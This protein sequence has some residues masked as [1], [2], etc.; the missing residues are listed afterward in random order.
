[1]PKPIMLDLTHPSETRTALGGG[2]SRRRRRRRGLRWRGIGGAGRLGAAGSD[3]GHGDE[4]DVGLA[5]E[6]VGQGGGRFRSN[7]GIRHPHDL[8]SRAHIN[9]HAATGIKPSTGHL[10]TMPG[11]LGSD[12]RFHLVSEDLPTGGDEGLLGAIWVLAV[13]DGYGWAGRAD[14]DAGSAVAAAVAAL[15]PR[16][17][18]HV[19]RSS[20]TF[21]I[22]SRDAAHDSAS[23][24]S[25]SNERATWP[26]AEELSVISPSAAVSR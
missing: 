1:M 12:D 16:D 4:R 24:R 11:A 8:G 19:H 20:A 14:L 10:A 23:A 18:G 25:L 9:R 17:T 26:T 22:R 15:A 3:A 21:L 7:H 5:A 13:A 6:G 2:C